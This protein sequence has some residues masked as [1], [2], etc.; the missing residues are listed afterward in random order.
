MLGGLIRFVIAI[1]IFALGAFCVTE[2]L[3]WSDRPSINFVVAGL[4]I[5]RQDGTY[6]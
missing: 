5:A 2:G 6:F 4:T 1:A 3:L